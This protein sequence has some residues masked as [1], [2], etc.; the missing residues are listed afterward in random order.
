LRGGDERH[1]VERRDMDNIADSRERRSVRIE[2]PASVLDGT[3]EFIL[4]VV[5]GVV[6]VPV[7]I[8][9]TVACLL[10]TVA[11]QRQGDLGVSV[12][13]TVASPCT[14]VSLDGVRST[15]LAL[16]DNFPTG[17]DGFQRSFR[18]SVLDGCEVFLFVHADRDDGPHAVSLGDLIEVIRD[19]AFT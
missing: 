10:V 1:G 8:T 2:S 14:K 18:G 9:E 5:C 12:N 19:G 7:E 11:M 17:L 16:E 6:C 13:P 3:H 15:T 4:G